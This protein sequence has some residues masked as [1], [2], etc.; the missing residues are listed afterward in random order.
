MKF[1]SSDSPPLL[2]VVYVTATL[3]YAFLIA[4]L[5]YGCT[6]PGAIDGVKFFFIPDWEKLK[7]I[8]VSSIP[9]GTAGEGCT[10]DRNSLFRSKSQTMQRNHEICS[11]H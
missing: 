8:N 10:D 1:E 2:Q 7:D 5:A 9:V 6:L 4:I 11:W 3:P